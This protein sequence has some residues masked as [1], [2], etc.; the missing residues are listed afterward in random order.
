MGL[1]IDIRQ[2]A[3]MHETD[4]AERLRLRLPGVRIHVGAEDGPLDDVVMIACSRLYPEMPARLSQLRL[5][6]KLGAGVETMVGA[7]GLPDHVRVA[8]LTAENAAD[9]IAEY[10]LAYV[11]AAQRNIPAHQTDAAD[12]RW[13]QLAPRSTAETTVAVLGLGHIGARTAQLFAGLGFRVMGWSRSAKSITGVECRYGSEALPGMLAEADHVC[14]ILPSTPDTRDLFDARMLARMK[15]GAQLINCGRGD[16]IVDADLEAA[17]DEGRPGHAVLDVFRT[18]PLP[19]EH[20]FWRHPGVTVTPHVSG[21]R[22]EDALM[23]VAENYLRLVDG[24]PLLNEVDRSAG[25]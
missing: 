22:V 13:R 17:L 16:L 2:P 21:W 9:E 8:R 11:L 19:P 10:C 20:P 12:G 7:A 23:D 6:Q 3:W 5:V 4:L 15:P 18:E 25:Y 14:A 24:R 1:L